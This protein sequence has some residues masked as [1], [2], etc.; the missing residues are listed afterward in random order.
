QLQSD[1][2]AGNARRYRNSL[3]CIISV[4]REEGIRGM[5]KGLSASILGLSET[6]LQF[7]LYEQMK[8]RILSSKM[9]K[10]QIQKGVSG[11]PSI[12]WFETFAMAASAKLIAALATYPHEVLRTRL[13]EV[14]ATTSTSAVIADGSRAAQ[15]GLWQTARK[16]YLE[17]GVGALYGGLTAHLMRVVPNAAILFATVEFVLMC[18]D[19][20]K[21]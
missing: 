7:V 21:K 1:G 19:K 17:E 4:M 13:R 6:T 18:A 20:E 2:G 11:A 8:K 15:R 14:P 16:I 10:A 9:E 5:Y 3:D 12:D